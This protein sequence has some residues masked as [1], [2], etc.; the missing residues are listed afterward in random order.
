MG[1]VEKSF[2]KGEI[3][4]KEGDVGKS[5]FKL[6][7]GK[8]GVY[9]DYA[10]KNPFR[11]G[12]LN[13]GE[14]FGEMA[15]LEASPRSATIVAETAVTVAEIPED[16][17]TKYFKENP[18]QII[19]LMKHLGNRI[20]AMAADYA[21]SQVLLK[22]LQDSD[23]AKKKSLFSK[24]KKHIDTYQ[25][26]KNKLT[27]PDGN[28]LRAEFEK[29]KDDNTGNTKSYS[30]GMFIFKEGKEENCMYILHSGVV[31]LVS[32]FRTKEEVKLKE[33]EAVTFFGEMGII[34]GEPRAATAIVESGT[35]VVETVSPE[36]LQNL[37]K[38]CPEK[39]ELIF[40]HMSYRLRKL[41]IDFVNACKEITET[42][43]GS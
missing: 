25:N 33:Y 2:K 41:N 18:D 10:K 11:L 37:I 34:S 22:Q 43:H 3:I 40:R 12:F 16:E 42:Y 31:S 24:I 38:T 30:R 21:E 17:M 4:M 36:D 27:E 35:A 26:N 29:L 20:Q 15:I 6:L 5:F 28:A 23:E 7:E 39:I 19:E 9:A 8:A 1:S 13:A 14:F 32:N